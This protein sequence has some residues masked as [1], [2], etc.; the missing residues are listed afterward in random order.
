MAAAVHWILS[1]AWINALAPPDRRGVY[2][3][4]YGTLIL[5]G[6]ALGPLLLTL[7]P[8]DGVLPFAL[9]AAAVTAAGIPI[10]FQR[11][12]LPKLDDRPQ[13]ASLGPIL[14][15]P[16]VFLA[17]LA[18]G[19]A[20]GALWTLLPV[21]GIERGIG[22]AGALHLLAALNVGTVLLQVPIGW[23]ADR[24]GAVSVLILCGAVGVAGALLLPFAIAGPPVLVLWA[25][26]FVWG[27]FVA[28]L[29]TIGMVELGRRFTGAGLAEANGLFVSSYSLGGL[30]GPLGAG[31]AM[32]L[33][34]AEAL[35]IA[36]ALVCGG[37]FLFA[38]RGRTG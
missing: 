34:G 30:A 5:S 35:P 13:R 2:V 19:L 23:L 36:V 8:I 17:A 14:I 16:V 37:F 15:A 38:V 1:E 18:S 11:H 27:A 26:A 3:G 22:E 21:Y 32:D 7:I 24:I 9:I 4:I 31:V 28:S 6:F 25:V 20:D 33:A 10:Y 29:Y 12:R